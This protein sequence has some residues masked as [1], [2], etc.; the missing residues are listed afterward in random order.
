VPP[1]RAVRGGLPAHARL[2]DL[3][4]QF[5]DELVK[6]G[7]ILPGAGGLVAELLGFGALLDPPPLV[8]RRR[9]GGDV[10]FVLEVPAFPALG[11]P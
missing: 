6:V 7:R 8:L 9:V 5:A 11:S 3:L 10:G 4:V 2:G 1:R